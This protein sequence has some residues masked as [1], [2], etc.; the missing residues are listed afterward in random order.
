MLS[1]QGQAKQSF[2]S[3]QCQDEGNWNTNV[4]EKVEVAIAAGGLASDPMMISITPVDKGRR[5]SGTSSYSLSLANLQRIS[6]GGGGWYLQ[7]L[8]I[9]CFHVLWKEKEGESAGGFIGTVS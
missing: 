1:T 7:L 2:E 6:G 5:W 8:L 4:K 9:G 3:F